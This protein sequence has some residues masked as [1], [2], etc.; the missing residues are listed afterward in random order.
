MIYR[1]LLIPR[2]LELFGILSPQIETNATRMKINVEIAGIIEL[3]QPQR[4][5]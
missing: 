1:F 5:F 4:L 2:L 3:V